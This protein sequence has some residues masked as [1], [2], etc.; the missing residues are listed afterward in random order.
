MKKDLENCE[1][2][3]TRPS[4]LIGNFTS[5]LPTI[6]WIVKSRNL[7]GNPSFWMTRA[8]FR[9][10]SFDSF[11]LFAPVQTILPELNIKAVVLGSLI[12]IMTAAN[13]W[14]KISRKMINRRWRLTFGLYSAFLACKA[15]FFKSNLQSKLTVDTMFLKY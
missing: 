3:R 12:L 9:A 2:V 8:Y 10:A 13:R 6:F 7:A 11:S 15:I 1:C 4:S 14:R 5:T